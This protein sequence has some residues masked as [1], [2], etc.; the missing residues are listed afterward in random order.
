MR[1]KRSVATCQNKSAVV[2]RAVSRQAPT[3]L[4]LV[5]C[6][7]EGDNA[8]DSGVTVTVALMIRMIIMSDGGCN[9]GVV[10]PCVG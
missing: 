8:D 9:G 6:V 3:S 1:P 7:D 4:T 5:S 2:R 10:V